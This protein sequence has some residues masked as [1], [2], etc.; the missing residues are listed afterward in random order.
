M[1]YGQKVAKQF[2]APKL[3]FYTVFWGVHFF[4]FG[5]GWYVGQPL[6][7]LG[8]PGLYTSLVGDGWER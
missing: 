4:L 7:C 6:R 8:G 3:F 2:T 5:Y 1:S